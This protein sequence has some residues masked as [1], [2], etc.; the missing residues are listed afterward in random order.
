M[1]CTHDSLVDK[2]YPSN[3]YDRDSLHQRATISA[4]TNTRENFPHSA[5]YQSGLRNTD[6]L[7]AHIQASSP[8]TGYFK[9]S[10]KI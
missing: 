4:L 1:C 2:T 7:L 9:N 10:Q 8:K 6:G 5:Y 3:V